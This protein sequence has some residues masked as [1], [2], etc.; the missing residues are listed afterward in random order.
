VQ[1]YGVK[2]G[3]MLDAVLAGHEQVGGHPQKQAVLDNACPFLQRTS[4]SQGVANRAEGAVQDQV[5]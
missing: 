4:Q 2:A 1:V 5:P 3:A